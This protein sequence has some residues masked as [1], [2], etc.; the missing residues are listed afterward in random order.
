MVGVLIEMR[1]AIQRKNAQGKKLW[2]LLAL[3]VVVLVLA[4]S[5]FVTG[6]AHYDH[7]G[8]GAD[9]LA[10][11]SFGW[12]LGWMTGPVLT[13]DDATLR[14]DYFKLLPVPPRKLARAILGA[15]FANVSLVFSLIAFSSL[16][17]YG[18]RSGAGAAL[19]GVLAVVLNLVLAVVASTVGVGVLGP[20]V[21]SR[22]GRDFG[23]MLVALVITLM[24]LASAVVPFLAKKLTGGDSPVLSGI[25]RGLPSGWGADAVQDAADGRWGAMALPL[26]GLV[27]LIAGLVL[28]WPLV[29][30]RR[31][32]MSAKGKSKPKAPAHERKPARPILPSTPTG[33]VI[34]KELR[35]YSR[36]MLRSVQLMIA[37]LVGV[38]ACV[39]PSFNGS[40]IMLPFAGLL[41]TVIAAAVFTN[42]Y[43]DD[44][45]AL[46][47]TLTT[48]NVEREDVRGRQWAW[49]LVTGPLGLLL[50]VFL[51]AV[52]GQHWAWPWVLSSE[53]ALVAGGT[54]VT[55]LVSVLTMYPLSQDGSPTPQRQVKAN[56]MLFC[57]PLV[58]CLPPVALLVA[59]TVAD[60]AA[61]EW[62]ALPVGLLW[63]ALLCRQLGRTATQRLRTRGPELFSLVRRPAS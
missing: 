50:T 48:P 46:W 37:F 47:L 26:A 24:S 58:C 4:G 21:S 7:H 33:A 17:A 32:T 40:T 49:F 44:G 41:F 30:A 42:L 53:T 1:A 38:L 6:L 27:A 35:M 11:L 18:A 55:V 60:T 28:V 10:T 51:T 20:T 15:N 62:A 43:G 52:S 13:G 61:L 54:G 63:G 23:T 57:V 39:I 3:L 19:V 16:I 45:S 25:V 29:L 5:T 8:A 14:L 31:L 12:L 56:L 22:R 59:G 2:G 36:S 9:V 34:G